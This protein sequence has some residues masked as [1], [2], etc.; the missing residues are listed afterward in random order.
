MI[1]F[2]HW[3]VETMEDVDFDEPGAIAQA[4]EL[5]GQLKTNIKVYKCVGAVTYIAPIYSVVKE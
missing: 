5:A 1:P 2:E 4:K 3:I